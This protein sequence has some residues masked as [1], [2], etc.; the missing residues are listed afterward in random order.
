MRAASEF[1]GKDWD[2]EDVHRNQSYDLICRHDGEVKHV[3]VKGTTT[4][5]TE[6]I[7]TLNEVRHARAYPNT[8][9]FVL[10]NITI[11]RSENGTVTATGGDEQVYDP[12]LIGNGTL[13]PL[14]FRYIVPDELGVSG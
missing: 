3:E 2:V 4:S 7:L 14:G 5:G 13:V 8:A 9:L 10:S 1:Y 12:W 11:E 6:V